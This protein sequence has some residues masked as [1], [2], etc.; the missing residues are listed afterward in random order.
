MAWIEV[1]ERVRDSP[2]RAFSLSP[3]AQRSHPR[4]TPTRP[5]TSE[6]GARFLFAHCDS[7]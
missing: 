2:L 6:L 4:V 7:P 3:C 1:R 5:A